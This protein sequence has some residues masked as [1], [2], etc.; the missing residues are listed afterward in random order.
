MDI[1]HPKKIK[2]VKNNS[3]YYIGVP[4]KYDHKTITLYVLESDAESLQ[5]MTS[6]GTIVQFPVAMIREVSLR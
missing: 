4:I 1:L 2:V 3:D 6:V 5:G